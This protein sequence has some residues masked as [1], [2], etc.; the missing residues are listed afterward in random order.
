[1]LPETG[2]SRHS[3]LPRQEAEQAAGR[4]WG[5]SARSEDGHRPHWGGLRAQDL[6]KKPWV[7]RKEKRDGHMAAEVGLEAA[8]LCPHS[9]GSHSCRGATPVELPQRRGSSALPRRL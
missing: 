7:G 8:A 4:V 3:I 6:R 2:Q 1:M 5:V 9:P